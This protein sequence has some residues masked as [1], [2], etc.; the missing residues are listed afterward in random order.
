MSYSRSNL[1]L[2]LSFRFLAKVLSEISLMNVVKNEMQER[3]KN[4][5]EGTINAREM[6]LK[7]KS[8]RKLG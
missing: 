7:T 5:I 4:Q 2:V 1:D 8:N 6:Y 3:K